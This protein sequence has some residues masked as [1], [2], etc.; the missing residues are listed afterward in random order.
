MAENLPSPDEGQKPAADSLP[1][2]LDWEIHVP[3]FRNPLILRQLGLAIG[4]PFGILLVVL[5][6]VKAYNG[7]ILVALLFLMTYVFILAL[8][9]GKY[10]VGFHL[11]SAG[12]KSHTLTRQAKRNRVVNWLTV[13]LGLFTGKFSAAGAGVLAMVG[14]KQNIRWSSVQKVRF[15]DSTRTILVRAGL[16]N[17]L[18]LF[19]THDNYSVVRMYL[20][21]HVRESVTI[22]S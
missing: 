21:A 12:I 10:Q 11:S 15:F 3:I 19:C 22:K 2:I 9:G 5:V 16:G 14:Q 6:I 7:V 8:Y 1:A 13:V 17:Q 4:I 20:L 18:A